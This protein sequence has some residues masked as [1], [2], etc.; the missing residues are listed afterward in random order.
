MGVVTS[1]PQKK[2]ESQIVYHKLIH[3]Q[4]YIEKMFDLYMFNK[5]T[6]EDFK[7]AL[8]NQVAVFW[9]GSV[10]FLLCKKCTGTKFVS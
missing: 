4:L 7:W 10:K 1:E 6:T 2:W 8:S 3:L 9:S 5:N